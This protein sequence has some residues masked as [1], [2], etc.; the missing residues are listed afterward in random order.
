MSLD[1]WPGTNIRRSTHNGFTMGLSADRSDIADLLRSRP[2]DAREYPGRP[3]VPMPVDQLTK[4]GEF[5]H[6]FSSITAGAMATG[7]TDANIARVARGI[8]K[9][10]GGFRWRYATPSN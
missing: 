6:H 8:R 1:F 9:T 10:A 3:G 4:D 7:A 5:V 2:E